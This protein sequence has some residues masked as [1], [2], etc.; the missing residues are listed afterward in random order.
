MINIR[1]QAAIS[2]LADKV[3]SRQSKKHDGNSSK[4]GRSEHIIEEEDA[5]DDLDEIREQHWRVADEVKNILHVGV[6]EITH[7][8]RTISEQ[9]PV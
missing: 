2:P 5:D 7:T 8:A 4:R 1:N 9:I 6:D 3:S